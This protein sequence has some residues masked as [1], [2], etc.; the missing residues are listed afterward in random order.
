MVSF[1]KMLSS[2]VIALATIPA[3]AAL[4]QPGMWSIDAELNGKPGR[5]IQ[6]DRQDGN[7]V[8]ATY[9][10]YRPDGSAT[11]YQAVGNIEDGKTFSAPLIEYKNGNP[12]GTH[13]STQSGEI[14]QNMGDI[15]MV[16]DS[17]ATGQ[18]L[19]Q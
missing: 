13:S 18:V 19:S 8:I 12:L 16:F 11:F 15:Q 2:S 4:P 9:F 6:I 5:G 7:V 17:E 14:S 1:K 3:V 10:G